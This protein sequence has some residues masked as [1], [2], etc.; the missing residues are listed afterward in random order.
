VTAAGC[1]AE[2]VRSPFPEAPEPDEGSLEED[3]NDDS[4]LATPVEQESIP[5]DIGLVVAVGCSRSSEASAP[6]LGSIQ[7]QHLEE[8]NE[9]VMPS[10]MSTGSFPAVEPR[11]Q[12]PKRVLQHRLLSLEVPLE[13]D[14]RPL[15]AALEARIGDGRRLESMLVAFH[16]VR[17]LVA[18]FLQLCSSS[19]GG[20]KTRGRQ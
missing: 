13:E 20:R 3:C 9:E 8:A 7:E 6:G 2:P 18:D 5:A 11:I 17:Q 10:S 1:N 19:I 14:S 12:V 16:P 15:G 4:R